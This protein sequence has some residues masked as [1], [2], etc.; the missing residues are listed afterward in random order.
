[1]ADPLA[2]VKVAG[3]ITAS[4]ASTGKTLDKAPKRLSDA[5]VEAKTRHKPLGQAELKL[6]RAARVEQAKRRTLPARL[7]SRR[8]IVNHL[9]RS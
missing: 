1:M 7:S 4:L 2:R 9:R 3:I 6:I 5:I 8:A